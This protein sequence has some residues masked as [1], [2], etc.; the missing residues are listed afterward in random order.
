MVRFLLAFSSRKFKYPTEVEV[1]GKYVRVIG[2][3]VDE[4]GN[5][6]VLIFSAA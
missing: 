2:I 6:I 1:E 4:A 3:S 5:V